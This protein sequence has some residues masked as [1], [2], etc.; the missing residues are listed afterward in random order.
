MHRERRAY[1]ISMDA[2]QSSKVLC[3]LMAI[4]T[5]DLHTGRVG[6]LV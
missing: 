1:D 3:D 6:Y 5:R 4:V 2:V